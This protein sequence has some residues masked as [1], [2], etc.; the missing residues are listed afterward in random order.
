MTDV[1]QAPVPQRQNEHK[2]TAEKRKKR[3]KQ[4]LAAE[5]RFRAYGL[6]AIALGLFFL[7]VLFASIVSNGYS[8]FQ[9]TTITLPVT[10]TEAVIDSQDRRADDPEALLRSNYNSILANA[11]AE[12]LGLDP[13]DQTTMRR[14]MRLISLNAG[15][16][17]REVVQDDPSVIGKTLPVTF[18]ASAPADAAFK[19]AGK[20]E[21]FGSGHGLNQMQEVWLSELIAQGSVSQSFNIGFLVN[22]ASSRPEAAGIGVALA[23]SFY[24]L[25]IVLVLALPIGVASAIYLE[26]FA[27][28]NRF[29]DLIEVNINNLAAV[30]SIVF[31]LLGLAFFIGYAG[32]PRSS[33][34][35]GGLVLTLL[36][37]PTIIIATRSALG[38]VPFSVREAALSVGASRM[39]AVFHHVLPLAAPGIVTGAI[40]GMA[41]ALGETAPL[42]L[43]GMVAFVADYPETPLD[44]ATALPVQI[45]MWAGEVQQGFIARTSAAIMVLL[46]F[47]LSLNVIAVVLRRR[48]EKKW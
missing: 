41:R 31:G 43:I 21:R 24:M 34:L 23:G 29:T 45:Y 19:S 2:A 10:F 38:A 28:R 47:L 35:V 18:L 44:A 12:A 4:R 13:A 26:E 9:Q 40:L 27:P 33:V 20:K 32:V 6:M 15:I 3:L 39:Q 25:V 14:A 11:V 48:F 42:L 37:L 22:G 30:P 17:L 36:T 7:A 5:R 16:R 1:T 46:V 8:A